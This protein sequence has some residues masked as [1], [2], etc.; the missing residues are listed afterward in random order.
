[1]DDSSP[2]ERNMIAYCHSVRFDYESRLLHN[3]KKICRYDHIPFNLIPF[4][5]RIQR[6]HWNCRIL[7]FIHTSRIQ[8][9]SVLLEFLEAS[10]WTDESRRDETCLQFKMKKHHIKT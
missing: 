9:R 7:I 1:M 10:D 6:M 8:I 3:Q 2:I 4:G 5:S